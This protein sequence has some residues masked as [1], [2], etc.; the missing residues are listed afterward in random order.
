MANDETELLEQ[1]L[2]GFLLQRQ[3]F[4]AQMIEVESALEEVEKTPQAYKIVG[5]IMVAVNPAELKGELNQKKEM[6]KIRIAN[7][8][9]QE[10]KIRERVGKGVLR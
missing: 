4:Q 6:L 3:A 2:Q 5:S 7:L 10:A 9:K 1:N 8:E